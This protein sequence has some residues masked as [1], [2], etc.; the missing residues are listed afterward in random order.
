MDKFG[1]MRTG[2]QEN[3]TKWCKGSYEKLRKFSILCN[4]SCS[5][6]Q[7]V[8][9]PLEPKKMSYYCSDLILKLKYG[10][11]TEVWLKICGLNTDLVSE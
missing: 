10:G 11:F 5:V 9:P 7:N 2:N 8:R 3:F 1:Y 4:I 6:V